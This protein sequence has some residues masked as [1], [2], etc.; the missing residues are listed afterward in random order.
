[1]RNWKREVIDAGIRMLGEGITIGTW[2]NVTVRDP[3]TGY[4]YLSPSGMPY[5]SL[6]EE[7]IDFILS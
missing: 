3:E 2:G 6:T 1:M 5:K 4:V 7:D